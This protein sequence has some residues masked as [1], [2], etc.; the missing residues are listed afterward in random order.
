MSVTYSFITKPL[1]EIHIWLFDDSVVFLD[2][3]YKIVMN[4]M[5][6]MNDIS[7]YKEERTLLECYCRL[8]AKHFKGTPEYIEETSRQ[9]RLLKTN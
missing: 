1:W 8:L 3:K 6:K 5:E 7:L 9:G 4:V 2:Q